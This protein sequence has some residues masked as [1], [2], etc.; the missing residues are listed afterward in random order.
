MKAYNATHNL[1]C[2]NQ[3]YVIG[4][5]YISDTLKICES[6]FH[7]C[8]NMS[9]VLNYYIFDNDFVL[10]EVEILGD[11]QF[12]DDKG[13]TNKMK[14][15]RIVPEEEWTFMTRNEKGN[16][17]VNY[18]DSGGDECWSEYDERGNVTYFKDSNGSECWSEYD[19]RGNETYYKNSDEYESWREYDE[20]GNETYYRNSGGF[21]RGVSIKN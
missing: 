16:R 5:T 8:N 14:I 3:T 17:V 12:E 11:T 18:K 9:D 2:R 7:F 10:I 13:V 1:K 20:K 21:E 4:E 15:L 19:E 6:G